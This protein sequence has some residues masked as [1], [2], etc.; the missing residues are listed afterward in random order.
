M[1]KKHLSQLNGDMLR[2]MLSS[3][4][5]LTRHTPLNVIP[6]KREIAAKI[7]EDERYTVLSLKNSSRLYGYCS[8]EKFFS[9]IKL[10]PLV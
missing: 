8:F 3:L 7:L 6:K 9:D 5:K 1:R 4:R 2:M 10:I